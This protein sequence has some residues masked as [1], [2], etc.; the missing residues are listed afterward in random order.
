MNYHFGST[1]SHIGLAGGIHAEL[2]KEDAFITDSTNP[3][4][5]NMDIERLV[6]CIEKNGAENIPFIRMEAST[7]LIGGQPFSIQNY[8]EVREIA[9]KYGI[10]LV[11]DA[12]LL[13][14]N[15]YLVKQREEEYKDKSL[16]EL[17]RLM[18]DLADMVYFSARKLTS[19]RGG[20]ICCN[21]EHLHMRMQAIV[22]VFEG[23]VTYGG[24]S[25][26]EMEAMVVGLY[27]SLDE[28]VISQS[29]SY[30]KFFVDEAVKRGI[31][32][33]TPPGVLGAHVDARKFCNHI[34]KEEYQAAALAS[35]FFIA[36]GVRGMEGGSVSEVKHDQTSYY[37]DMEL[38]RLAF[39][40]RVFTLSQSLYALDR[41]E[42][43]Y[44]NRM[45]IG[46]MKFVDI[47]GFPR[48]FRS[49]LA[50]ISNWPE[51]LAKKF[52]ED[53]GDSL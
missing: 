31:P 43:L 1:I 3:F 36:S 21:D 52:K 25:M 29:P 19:T 30:I 39:P 49:P 50:P 23:Y 9:D 48:T 42:W 18:C 44:D 53:F 7:N 28:D 5:G 35:A 47:P 22:G 12:S 20:A 26:K 11:L 4:K 8:K 14:E 13:G 46:G 2:L 6:E 17:I 45:L 40:R 10:M 16:G 24:M 32:M 27:E 15:A 37:A 34:E 38:L 33:V 51:M 41:L